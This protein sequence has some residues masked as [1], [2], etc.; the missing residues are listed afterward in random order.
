M[1]NHL[2]TITNRLGIWAGERTIFQACT[3]HSLFSAR[4]A[5]V[6]HPACRVSSS[7]G[8]SWKISVVVMCQTGSRQTIN[9]SRAFG[10]A[11]YHA[12]P[13][14]FFPKVCVSSHLAARRWTVNIFKMNFAGF[15]GSLTTEQKQAWCYH[16]P[17]PGAKTAM[18]TWRP[19]V[20]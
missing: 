10:F 5:S 19:M 12:P 3:E 11:S 9:P 16:F 4:L 20:G 7:A 17:I 1:T 15:A 18:P 8:Y 2:Q 13:P 14:A 6:L